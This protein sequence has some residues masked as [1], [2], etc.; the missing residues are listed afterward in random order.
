MTEENK[1]FHEFGYPDERFETVVSENLHCAICSCVFKDPVMCKNEHCFC[2]GCITK[3][4]HYYHTCPSCNQDLTVESLADVP[5]ILRNLLSEQRIRCDHHERG[6]EEIVQLG[7]LASHVAVCGKA[8][9][10]CANEECSSEINR[11]DQF[12]HQGEECRFRKVKCQNC[13]EMGPVVKK[14]STSLGGLVEKLNTSVDEMKTG[15]TALE[16]RFEGMENSRSDQ[17][18]AEDRS[19]DVKDAKHPNGYAYVVA[20]G[21]N[22]N[23]RSLNSVEVFDKTTNSWIQMKSMKKH[24]ANASSVVYNGDTVLVTGG[25]SGDS[26]VVSSMEQFSRNASPFVPPSWSNLSVNLPRP[27]RGHRTVLY[28]DRLIVLG[29]YDEDYSGSDM[30]YEIQLHFPFTTKVLA[31]LSRAITGCG[32][33]LVN[34]KILMFGGA[35]SSSVTMY[36]ITKNEFKELAPLP[37]AVCNMATAKY[38]E[39]VILAAGG[40]HQYDN[41][42]TVVSYNIETEENT[43][44]PPMKHNRWECCAVVDGNSLVV[45]GGQ[46]PKGTVS[47]VEAF[48]FKTSKWNDLPSMMEARRG[49]IAEIV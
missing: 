48:D 38:G 27:L 3:H 4:L 13:E 45:M 6:C 16:N 8:P 43:E 33:V 30:I 21:Y 20:G 7:N 19:S 34:D 28:N 36:D 17:A 25:I 29:G 22:Q 32:V 42:N 14:I 10:V 44:L 31:K 26:H 41:R 49:F 18:S 15:L 47:S 12:R 5:R 40:T 35:T 24:R 46:G 39:N 2:R 37:Y 11:E 1:H 9:V 23:N